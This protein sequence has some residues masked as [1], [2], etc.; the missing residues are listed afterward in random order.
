VPPANEILLLYNEKNVKGN[1]SPTKNINYFRLALG[2]AE[3][4][5]GISTMIPMDSRF[6]S[7]FRGMN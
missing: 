5:V 4:G 7:F 2:G 1:N 6:S 3:N